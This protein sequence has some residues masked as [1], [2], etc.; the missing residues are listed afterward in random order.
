[1]NRPSSFDPTTLSAP[2]VLDQ[3]PLRRVLLLASLVL[4][5][6]A[7]L[8]RVQAVNPPPDGDYGNGNTAE[9]LDALFSLSGGLGNNTAIGTDA[10]FSNTFGGNNTAIGAFSLLENTNGGGNTATGLSALRHN[11]LGN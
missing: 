6:F 4:I 11:T 5:G 2:T 10:L 9:G 3:S 7:L 8:P 1:M